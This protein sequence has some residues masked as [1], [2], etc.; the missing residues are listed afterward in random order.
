MKHAKRAIFLSV[1]VLMIGILS[2]APLGALAEGEKRYTG[3]AVSVAAYSAAAGVETITYTR[4]EETVYQLPYS[5]PHYVALSQ[6]P[7][8]CAAVAGAILVGF[9]DKYYEELIPNFTSYYLGTGMYRLA[10]NN[11][12]PALMGTLYTAMKTNVGGI[13][14]TEVNTLNG[15][16]NYFAGKG[17]GVTYQSLV[18]LSGFQESLLIASIQN[19]YPVLLFCK[20]ANFLIIDHEESS[21][22]IELRKSLVN[23]VMVAYGYCQY[24]YYNGSGNF[25]TDTYLLVASGESNS[26]SYVKINSSDWIDSAYGVIVS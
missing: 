21:D 9:Y 15:L 20:E 23:H 18:N 4:R 2:A 13:G 5:V 10:D 8:S 11:Y 26:S 6:Y 7:Y 17:H 24:R 25:R 16:T 1:L 14:A 12:I 22:S 3:E 19:Q